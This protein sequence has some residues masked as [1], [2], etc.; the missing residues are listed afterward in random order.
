MLR[1][2]F[3][4]VYDQYGSDLVYNIDQSGSP[5]LASSVTQPVNTNYTNSLRYAGSREFANRYRQR[6]K[7]AS[8]SPRPPSP[9][10]LTKAWALAFKSE[11]ALFSGAST[12][13]T[14][15]NC[16]ASDYLKLATPVACTATASSNKTL[17]SH[18]LS[19][20]ILSLVKPGRRQ[21][22]FFITTTLAAG[23]TYGPIAPVP[24]IE[25][26]LPGVANKPCTP[27]SATQN[28]YQS[29]IQQN[30]LS[31]LDNLN[32]MDR[33]RISGTNTCYSVFGCNTFYP[34]QAAGL[35]TWTNAGYSDYNAG[36]ITVRRALSNN[37][38]FDF[39]YTLS[40]SIDNSSGA[41]SGAGT[42][43]AILQD[44]FNVNAFRG[45][46]DFDSRHNITADVLVRTTFR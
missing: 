21:W 39:N 45:P 24:F 4:M 38:A 29:W 3:A 26:M 23:Q 41:E 37:F 18:S 36:T 44:A 27:G 20:K 25:N 9:A 19:S 32:Q 35:P 16:P 15:S 33:Q 14:P 28:Y 7:A 5:G 43:G 17:T 34:L 22:A 31:D 42:G 11:S 10:A 8:P 46:S 1:G 6:R 12:P 13:T 30:G 2:G 40:H